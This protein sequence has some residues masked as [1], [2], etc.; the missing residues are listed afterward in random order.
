MEESDFMVLDFPLVSFE[1]YFDQPS[2]KELDVLKTIKK[3]NILL[4]LPGK[5][6][7]GKTNKESQIVNQ[8]LKSQ[9]YESL[10]SIHNNSFHVGL[11]VDISDNKINEALIQF[12]QEDVVFGLVRVLGKNIEPEKILPLF[13]QLNTTN[14]QDLM[15]NSIGDDDQNVISNL[16]NTI[17]L[18]T[19]V[20]GAFRAAL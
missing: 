6:Q 2:Q 10:M 19:P 11:M 1:D 9:D 7:L 8:I 4:Y 20:E 15:G 13:A 14:F 3:L 17:K 5:H 18:G 16:L 12:H